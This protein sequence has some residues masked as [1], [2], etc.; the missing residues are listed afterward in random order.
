[1]AERTYRHLAF[2]VAEHDLPLF[3]ERLRA[4]GVD[5]KPPRPRV[6]GEGQS[7]YFHDFDNHL[8]EL[9]SGTLTERLQR[10][11]QA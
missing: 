1:M 4:L 5:V 2:K 9:H 11:R 10:Y 7:L 6:E 3:E 8:F